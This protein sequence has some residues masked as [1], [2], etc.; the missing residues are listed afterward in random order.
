ML[1]FLPSHILGITCIVLVTINT[2]IWT[3]PVHALA[4]AK[5]LVR[6]RAWQV[7]CTQY[8]MSTVKGWLWGVIISLKLIQKITWDIEGVD[9]LSRHEWYFVNSNHQSWT[10]IVVLLNIFTFRIPFPKF[11]LK[12][13]LFYIPILGTAWWAL[14]YPF[15]NRY[16]KEYLQKHP[17][18]RGKDLETTRKACEKYRYTPVS[19][20]N[21]TEGTRFTF[22]KH[23]TQ[24][25]PYRQLLRPKAGGF[26]YALNAMEGKISNLLDVTI[27][28]P[29]GPINFWNFLCGRVSHVIV[30]ITKYVIPEEFLHGNYE[31]DPDFRERFQAWIRDLWEKK[32][33][34]INEI[35][36]QYQET[37]TGIPATS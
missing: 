35:L 25:S 4:F 36:R 27:V 20:L 26:A 24:K 9:D 17:Q 34:L 11:F 31:D 37:P 23:R 13:E 6:F 7:R 16:S 19:I 5:C 8:L 30:R 21:F 18:K 22:E 14:D 3:I 33:A 29:E 15:M 32:D 2:L 10:D 28:Y 12:K 1:S